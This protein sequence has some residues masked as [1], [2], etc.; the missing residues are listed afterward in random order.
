MICEGEYPE[1]I[2]RDEANRNVS[3]VGRFLRV[4]LSIPG[5]GRVVS[6]AFLS[7]DDA[8]RGGERGLTETTPNHESKVRHMEEHPGA[9][10]MKGTN[11]FEIMHTVNVCCRHCRTG[12]AYHLDKVNIS[13]RVLWVCGV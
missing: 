1:Q 11:A 9:T 12:V 7:P 4:D 3:Q 10:A 6:T 8:N 5:I 2:K 13:A